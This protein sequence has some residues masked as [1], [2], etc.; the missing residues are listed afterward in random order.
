MSVDVWEQRVLLTGTLDDSGLRS[1]IESLAK[2]DSRIKILHN[3]IQVVTTTE[4]WGES[5]SPCRRQNWKNLR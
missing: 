2:Q 5:H 3:H 4:K 1:E